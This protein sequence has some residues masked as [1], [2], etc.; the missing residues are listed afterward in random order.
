M[1]AFHFVI[2]APDHYMMD[3]E[4]YRCG[5]VLNPDRD[6]DSETLLFWKMKKIY[7]KQREEEFEDRV[8]DWIM[9]VIDKEDC[10]IAVAPGHSPSSS[11]PVLS[12]LISTL[13]LPANI[14]FE[15]LLE[16]V[17][18]VPKSSDGGPRDQQLHKETIRVNEETLEGKKVYIFDDVWTT[19]ATLRACGEL[20]K[21]AGAAKVI[22][23]AVGKTT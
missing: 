9:S 15:D 8:S 3:Y 18:E 16:R 5:G 1:A 14:I 17:I 7:V 13:D 2:N 19:G 23:C 22:L 4:P 11:T 20:V 10:V 12:D 6:Y 21:E